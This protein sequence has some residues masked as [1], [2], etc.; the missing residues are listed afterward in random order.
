M[1]LIVE[2][3]Y[4]TATDSVL[5][6][7]ADLTLHIAGESFSLKSRKGDDRR[8]ITE[9]KNDDGQ[10]VKEEFLWDERSTPT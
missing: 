3:R 5:P 6:K 8:F 1:S 2:G 7:D 9:E 10:M 4:N